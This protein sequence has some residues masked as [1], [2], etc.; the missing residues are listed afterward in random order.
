MRFFLFS[1]V[2][3]SQFYPTSEEAGLHFLPNLFTK[4]ECDE[5]IKVSENYGWAIIPDSI[6]S[7]PTQ[8]I[9]VYLHGEILVPEVWALIEPHVAKL[10]AAMSS[11]VPYSCSIHHELDWLFVRRYKAGTMRTSLK[12]HHDSN[13]HSLNLALNSDTDFEG[14]NIYFIPHDSPLGKNISLEITNNNPELQESNAAAVNP[15]LITQTPPGDENY[16]FPSIRAGHGYAHNHT[17]WHGIIPVTRGVKYSLLFFF[18]EA[19]K[20]M[21]SAAS[22][23]FMRDDPESARVL[24]KAV[25]D[26]ADRGRHSVQTTYQEATSQL[27]LSR[28]EFLET[29]FL[30]IWTNSNRDLRRGSKKQLDKVNID[31]VFDIDSRLLTRADAVMYWY[32]CPGFFGTQHELNEYMSVLRNGGRTRL[33]RKLI[34]SKYLVH[35]IVASQARSFAHTTDL[36]HVFFIVDRHS[37]TI[38]GGLVIR[39]S[40]LQLVELLAFD[41]A[42]ADSEADEDRETVRD[43]VESEPSTEL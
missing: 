25:Q 6:D 20:V 43:N 32:S 30:S 18:D 3:N 10:R 23:R 42:D 41:D 29:L 40:G 4:Q 9:E 21:D 11:V 33:A 7:K 37:K 13:Q 36:H 26:E 1:T 19:T 24:Q 15:F 27:N 31:V 12:G 39:G 14:G 17:L 5:L 38:L 34:A 28:W 8:D 2:V 22:K 35:D 16:Y